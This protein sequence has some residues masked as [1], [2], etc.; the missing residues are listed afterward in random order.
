ME[1]TDPYGIL[2]A[3]DRIIGYNEAP[4]PLILDMSK[5]LVEISTRD[6]L[7]VVGYLRMHR[8]YFKNV[9]VGV[10]SEHQA[11]RFELGVYHL[12]RSSPNN[13]RLLL[14]SH[15]LKYAR[16]FVSNVNEEISLRCTNCR[17]RFMDNYYNECRKC[18]EGS[19][20]VKKNWAGQFEALSS[21]KAFLIQ[22]QASYREDR[23]EKRLVHRPTSKAG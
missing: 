3:L 15:H 23:Y 5:N 12:S 10:L 4:R 13:G 1:E 6:H 16:K 21:M 9:I 20:Y 14:G 17:W 19:L 7:L 2:I 11:D 22:N 18:K 8:E